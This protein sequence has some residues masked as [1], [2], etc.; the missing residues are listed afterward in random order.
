MGSTAL[1]RRRVRR[2]RVRRRWRVGRRDGRRIR[3]GVLLALNQIV[4]DG[5]RV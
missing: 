3:R 2:R 4:D 5:E 1:D